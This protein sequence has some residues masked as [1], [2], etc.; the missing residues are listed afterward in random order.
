MNRVNLEERKRYLAL[1]AFYLGVKE[2]VEGLEKKH[3]EFV[4]NSAFKKGVNDCEEDTKKS[5]DISL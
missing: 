4:Y 1:Q 3:P 2:L 5:N